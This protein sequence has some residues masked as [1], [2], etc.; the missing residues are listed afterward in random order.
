LAQV[1]GIARS[2]ITIV[3]GH[4]SRAKLV[5]V[6]GLQPDDVRSRF[7]VQNGSPSRPI[8]NSCSAAD[9]ER[10]VGGGGR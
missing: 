3:R 4:G 10:S 9:P 2:N 6:R 8:I 1:L 7:E 5:E